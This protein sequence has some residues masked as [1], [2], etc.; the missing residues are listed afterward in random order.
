MCCSWPR[1][2]SATALAAEHRP[3]SIPP[4]HARIGNRLPVCSRI[5]GDGVGLL[6]FDRGTHCTGPAREAAASTSGYRV[7]LVPLSSQARMSEERYYRSIFEAASDGLIIHDVENDCVV[8]AN[9]AA[10][11]MHGYGREEFISLS[12]TTLIHP[13]SQHL[14]GEYVQAVQSGG[15]PERLVV[16][17]RRDGTLFYAEW[18]GA[19]ITYRGRRCLLSVVRD[20]SDRVQAERLL[21]Q[22][23]Q[24]RTREQ[25]TL[26]EISQTLA[27]AL[28]LRPALILDQLRVIIEY[29]RAGLFALEDSALVALAIRGP[30]QMQQAAPFRVRLDGSDTLAVLFNRHR[31]IRIADVWSADPAAQYLR[32]LLDEQSAV[33][34]EGMRAWMWVP[35]VVKG[36]VIG[37]V[38]VAHPEQ[39]Y[40]TAHHADLALTVAN[41]AAITMVNAELYER[42][43]ALAAVHER[44]RLAQ[45]LHDAV[46]QSLFSAGLIA[47]VLP[48]LW[49]RD[50]DEGRRSLEDLRRLT[51]G[52]LAEMRALL[53]E[54]RPSILTD[55][56][57]GDLLRQLGSAFT[58]RTN[59]PVAVTVTGQE[60]MPAEVQV[61]FYRV[62]QEG[63]N[64]IGKHA[65]ADQVAIHLQ[66]DPGVI[67]LELCD[68]GRGFDPAHI[69]PGRSGLGMMR[70]RAEAVGAMLSIA[71]QPE[72]GTEITIRWARYP[73]QEAL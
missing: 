1:H 66:C 47:E 16:H 64:N 21:Q 13:E 41:Q 69:A 14:F 37:G 8:E 20:V 73:E 18:H 27:S 48:R 68:D 17:V 34:L 38:G 63:L 70:E 49:E 39:D 52:A 28:E 33:L 42:A 15:M 65:E 55:T 36:R 9:P 5:H 25:S 19:P 44:Q 31:P 22:R 67:E 12:P 6:I 26:L 24:A 40:F 53:A 72:H 10:A 7:H 62:C 60:H 43:Q 51:R 32:S 50:P 3:L 59:I 29:S 61:A 2:D 4:N 71:S 46:N 54:L 23:V 45:N 57:L 56:D 58:G 11:G 35:L 30:Q